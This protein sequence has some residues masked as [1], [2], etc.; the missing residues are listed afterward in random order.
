MADGTINGRIAKEVF[1]AMVETGDE[2]GDIVER[3]GLRQA[4]DVAAIDAAIDAVLARQVE[5][6]ADGQVPADIAIRLAREL[7]AEEHG[8]KVATC[9]A[10]KTVVPK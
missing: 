4:V 1:E 2:A 6:L 9:C 7:E 3:K 10:P 8:T 5:K